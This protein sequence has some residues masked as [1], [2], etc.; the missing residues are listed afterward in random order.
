MLPWIITEGVSLLLEH[1]KYRNELMLKMY[2]SFWDNVARAEDSAWK[3][4]A[5][6]IGVFAAL[7][8]FSSLIGVIGVLVVFILFSSMA[9]SLMIRAN[10]WYA[11]NLGLISNLE[12]EF[13][14]KEDYGRLIP[15][16]FGKKPRFLNKEIYNIQGL[17]YYFINIGVILL[18]WSKLDPSGQQVVLSLLGIC[19]ALILFYGVILCWYRDYRKF[20]VAAKG[21][22]LN[23]V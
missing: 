19:T 20:V 22:D 18:L 11:R 17:T 8:F 4:F 3:M 1:D 16:Y 12:K 6:Y 5:A 10:L 2:S 7:H 14:N 13:L 9:V 21:K 15:R 23:K